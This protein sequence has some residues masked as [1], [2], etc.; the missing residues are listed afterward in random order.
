[1][2]EIDAPQTDTI[3]YYV[4]HEPREIDYATLLDVAAGEYSLYEDAA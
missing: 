3:P 4:S 1:M 2:Y